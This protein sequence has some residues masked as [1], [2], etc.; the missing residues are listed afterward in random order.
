[1]IYTD[2]QFR[3]DVDICRKLHK[4]HG[5]SYYFA[6][7]FF[8]RNMRQA[9]YV[10][11]GFFRVP[12]EMVDNPNLSLREARS[13]N[14]AISSQEVQQTLQNWQK[15]WQHA[16]N[17]G[18]SDEPVLRATAHVFHKY[19]IPYEYS[20]SFLSAM[21]QDTEKSRYATYEELKQYMY[22]SAAVVGLMMSYVIGFSDKKAL[23]YAEDL[24]YAMQLTNFL[25]DIREDY[26]DRNRIYIPKEDLERFAIS[27]Y[28]IHEH[29]VSD[30]FKALMQFEIKRTREIYE[31]SK[32]GI[33]LLD[34]RG[35]FAVKM[36]AVLYGAIL[37]KIEEVDYD[38]FS[39][40][41]STSFGEK[42]KLIKS[43]I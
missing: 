36:A 16:Y 8:P 7:K 11:Y 25:R 2:T 24:G 14:V 17:T 18:E 41:V 28:G 22:G 32:A 27:E 9:T 34:K 12:D 19:K 38:V 39:S 20:E 42:L 23:T 21:I 43:A 3:K 30:N 5:K 33:E 40:R 13:N 35:Q 10:L 29:I 26:E 15:K 1:M 4:K 31:R 6:T 37:G